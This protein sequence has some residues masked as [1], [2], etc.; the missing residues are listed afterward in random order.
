LFVLAF[1]FELYT[2]CDCGAD[3]PPARGT[4]EYVGCGV[5]VYAGAEYPPYEYE[6]EEYEGRYE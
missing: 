3:E 6:G 2:Y 4:Y 5:Y 1:V